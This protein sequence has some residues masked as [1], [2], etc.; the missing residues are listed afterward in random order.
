[1]SRRTINV[2]LGLFT[3]FVMSI[4]AWPLHAQYYDDVVECR[5]QDYQYAECGAPF[6]HARLVEKM[7]DSDCIEGQTWGFRQGRIWVNHG[8][9]GRFAE[10][11]SHRND[12]AYRERQSEWHPGPGWDQQLSFSCESYDFRYTFCAIDVGGG[13]RVRFDRQISGSACIEG[14]TW[15]WNRAGV[16]V[17]NGCAAY[18]TIERRWR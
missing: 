8:C 5:S 7:S 14:R 16:W 6:R 4:V 10:A 11:S 12:N 13:G 2:L 17:D 1:M 18:F 3:L 15:G 9:A